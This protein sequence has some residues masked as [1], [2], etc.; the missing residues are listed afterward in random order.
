[1]ADGSKTGSSVATVCAMQDAASNGVRICAEAG[2]KTIA[3]GVHGTALAV[4]C[5][6][7]LIGA[8]VSVRSL[9]NPKAI[10]ETKTTT[11]AATAISRPS[12]SRPRIGRAAARALTLLGRVAGCRRP[13][14][15]TVDTRRK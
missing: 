4:G 14:F 11:A 3:A 1:M 13:S 9:E 5:G 7:G 15:K 2:D 12:V 10:S 8:G 6:D